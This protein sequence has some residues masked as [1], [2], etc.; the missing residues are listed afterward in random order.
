M[1]SLRKEGGSGGGARAGGGGE[2]RVGLGAVVALDLDEKGS[3]GGCGEADYLQP[4]QGFAQEK[5]G[6]EADL[7]QHGVV[8]DAG[9]C[10]RE[11]TKGVV[12]EG[13]GCG[14]VDDCQPNDNEPAGEIE[15]WWCFDQET[16]PQQNDGTDAH[17]DHG[18]GQWAQPALAVN[19]TAHDAG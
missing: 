10:R 13:E 7:D 14:R 2:W 1:D 12:P 4:G 9:L 17:A 19:A 18:H 16:D 6:E 5:P 11:G 3:E 8:D 15:A